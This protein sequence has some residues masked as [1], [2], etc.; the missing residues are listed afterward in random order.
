MKRDK[1]EPPW[2]VKE[3]TRQLT[4]YKEEMMRD[5]GPRH[6]AVQADAATLAGV[7]RRFG[8]FLYAKRD[9]DAA[10]AQ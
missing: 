1:R 7:H 9:Y 10:M 5:G 4:K 8:D 6:V 3:P 2:A